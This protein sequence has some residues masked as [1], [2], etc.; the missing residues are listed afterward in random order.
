[1]EMFDL[2]VGVAIMLTVSAGL[3]L[4]G[5][6]IAILGPR[7]VTNVLAIVTIAGVGAYVYY[8]R[9]NMM[10][11]VML[12][13]SNLIVLG[14]WFPVGVGFLGGLAWIRVYGGRIRK[15]IYTAVLLAV[16]VFALVQPLLGSPPECKNVWLGEVCMQT[17]D[18]TCSAAC[19]ATLLK[20]V[21]IPAEESEMARLSLTRKGTTWQG[22]Y[23]GLK[24]K[25]QGTEWDVRVFQCSAAELRDLAGGA[26]ILAVG[27]PRH[28][29]YDPRYEYEY[30]WIPGQLHSV[31]LF[32][33][34]DRGFVRIGEPTPQSGIEIWR[35]KDLELLWRGIGLRL[36]PRDP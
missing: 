2:Y 7:W 32:G 23:R 6:R 19:A 17:S 33:F 31:V 5:R 36:V 25:T 20:T 14:N 10:M 9:D 1:M 12:P 22:L 16:G 11:A 26:K 34:D 15:G 24:L 27:L 13:Y 28:G 8:L 3:F 18:A 21:G 30:G 35:Q 4:I 29:N